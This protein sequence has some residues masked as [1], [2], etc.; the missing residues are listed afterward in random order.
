MEILAWEFVLFAPRMSKE[1][2]STICIPPDRG[3]H[4]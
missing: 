1:I 3:L 2:L 4:N